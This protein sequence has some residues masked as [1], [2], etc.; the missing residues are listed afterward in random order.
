MAKTDNDRSG[1]EGPAQDGIVATFVSQLS[2]EERMLVLLQQELYDGSWEA[3][4]SDLSNR[5]DG[6]PYI[7]KLASRI[8]DDIARIEKLRAFEE[9]QGVRLSDY[10][11]PPTPRGQNERG[12]GQEPG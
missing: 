3:M 8:Q 5:L 11:E 1:Q 2:E 7:F 12:G 10:V 9:E 4:L 6:R